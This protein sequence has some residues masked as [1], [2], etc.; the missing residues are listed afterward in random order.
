MVRSISFSG[1]VEG[2]ATR[3]SEYAAAVARRGL[4]FASSAASRGFV[5]DLLSAKP[6]A[7]FAI[8]GLG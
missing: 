4:P 8:F 5:A 7:Y 3:P 1:G 2:V 6:R